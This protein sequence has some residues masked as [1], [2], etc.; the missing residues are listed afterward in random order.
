MEE[1][2]NQFAKQDQIL[3]DLSESVSRMR[4][5]ATG[6]QKELHVQFEVLD[7]LDEEVEITQTNLSRA[8]GKLERVRTLA[9]KNGSCLLIG[10]L[11]LLIVIFI[12]LLFLI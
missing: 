9:K 12:V 4:E 5:V 10:L 3:E 1:V 8:R 7:E 2:R 6:T 11:C